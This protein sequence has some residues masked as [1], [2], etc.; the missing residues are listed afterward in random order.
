MK[1]LSFTATVRVRM[2]GG[3]TVFGRTQKQ[4]KGSDIKCAATG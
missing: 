1:L 3:S 2:G 4:A